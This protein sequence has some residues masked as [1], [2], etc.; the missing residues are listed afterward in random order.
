MSEFANNN[1][2]NEEIAGDAL[3]ELEA[4]VPEASDEP[5]IKASF[6]E[7]DAFCASYDGD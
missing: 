6:S 1:E 5:E 3:E 2:N 4:L 7:F